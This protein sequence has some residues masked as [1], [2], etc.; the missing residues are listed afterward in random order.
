MK[1]QKLTNSRNVGGIT[2]RK[3]FTLIE[4]LAIIVILAII[5][6][7]TVPVILNIIENSKMGAAKDSAYGY[8][9]AIN[10]YYVSELSNNKKLMLNGTYEV[11]ANGVLNGNF[12]VTENAEDRIIPIDGEKPSSGELHYTNN[13][14]TE[15]WLV[16]G[17]Y[18]VIFNQ[19]GTVTTIKNSG[20]SLNQQGGGS[21]ETISYFNNVEDNY[22]VKYYD[23]YDPEYPEEHDYIEINR[24]NLQE[25]DEIYMSTHIFANG[26]A[27]ICAWDGTEEPL[28]CIEPNIWDCEEV[29]TDD[30]FTCSNSTGYLASKIEEFEQKGFSINY[31]VYDEYLGIDLTY[32]DINLD[33]QKDGDIDGFVYGHGWRTRCFAGVRNNSETAGCDI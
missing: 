28:V 20:S 19:G 3:A 22:V 9:D 18:R 8:K 21:G 5:A 32:N 26:K 15:G 16:I 27:M 30:T 29:I 33:I 25:N 14:L 31:Y 23:S 4:L 17:D 2:Q 1:K 7:I 6:V 12:G 24:E 11:K 13:V 10:K